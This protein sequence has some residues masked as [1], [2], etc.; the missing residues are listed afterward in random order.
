MRLIRGFRIL[1]TGTNPKV[2]NRPLRGTI[3]KQVGRWSDK[4]KHLPEG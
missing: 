4:K 3:N 2:F 1:E